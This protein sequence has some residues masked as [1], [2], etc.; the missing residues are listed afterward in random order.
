MFICLYR[1]TN[2]TCTSLADEYC[3]RTNILE[4]RLSYDPFRSQDSKSQTFRTGT[5]RVLT[6]QYSYWSG[7]DCSSCLYHQH[8]YWSGLVLYCTVLYCTVP[9]PLP[10]YLKTNHSCTG[11][12]RTVPV[13]VVV[14]FFTGTVI[15]SNRQ[16][17]MSARGLAILPL[18]VPVQYKYLCRT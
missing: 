1:H 9:V 8:R 11:T 3:T 6:V 4:I 17:C 5:V 18:A 10:S 15:F 14:F 13:P 16:N 7:T 2:G 12:V